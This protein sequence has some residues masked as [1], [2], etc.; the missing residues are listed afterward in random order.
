M[1][2]AL[3]LGPQ[4]RSPNLRPA[5]DRAGLR[6][7]VVSITAGWQEREGELT[8]LVDHLEAPVQDLRLYERAE[9]VFHQDPG[10]HAAYRAR[11]NDLRLL[12]DLYR[13]RLQHAKAAARELW[14][15]PDDTP[16]VRR[17]R[18]SAISALRRLDSEHAR[19]LRA[20]HLR[21]D[22]AV[23]P[24]GH[25]LLAGQRAGLEALIAS[26]GVI[27]IAGGHLPVLLNRLR[28]FG[29]ERA[30]RTRPL[31]AW[32]AGAMVLS[33]RIVLYHDHPP[34]GAGDAELFEAG[35]GI[36]PGTVFLPHAATR[37]ALD[38]TDRVELLARRLAP[39]RCCTLDDGD[40]LLWRGGRLA[41]AEG[42]RRLTRAGRLRP[43][44]A[45]A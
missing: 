26:A 14:R 40:M 24:S 29:L 4:F 37:L 33:E 13:L 19:T 1:P 38:D 31:V 44:E 2:D 7:P 18:R 42:S 35:L 43:A 39:A 17:A 8:S 34:S 6:G 23:D 45:S 25:P 22:R 10:L 28:L 20:A 30:L 12:Q 11:Q 15:Q 5:L 16:A 21:F 27:C 32:S 41:Y 36:V 9:A 3:I